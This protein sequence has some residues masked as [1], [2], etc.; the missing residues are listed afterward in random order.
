MCHSLHW[1]HDNHEYTPNIL[2]GILLL[3]IVSYN[4]SKPIESKERTEELSHQIPIDSVGLLELWLMLNN[5][6]SAIEC[7]THDVSFVL[8]D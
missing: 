7:D 6:I 5:R 4:K 3:S 8:T 1:L 2:A